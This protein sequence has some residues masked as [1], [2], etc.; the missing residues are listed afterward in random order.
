MARKAVL[1]TVRLRWNRLDPGIV[2]AFGRRRA[3][4]RFDQPQAIVIERLPSYGA[5]MKGN[6][7]DLLS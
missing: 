5:T 6:G 4:R 1:R 3:M 2:A 7:I